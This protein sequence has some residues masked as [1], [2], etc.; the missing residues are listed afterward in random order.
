MDVKPMFVSI[1]SLRLT[2]WSFLKTQVRPVLEQAMLLDVIFLHY[3][4]RREM[5]SV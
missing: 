1:G 5:A 2:E 3:S 4:G